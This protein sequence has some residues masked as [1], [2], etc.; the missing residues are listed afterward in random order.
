M[1]LHKINFLIENAVG[2]YQRHFFQKYSFMIPL[3]KMFFVDTNSLGRKL[4]LFEV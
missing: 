2:K 1:S 3:Q 4:H